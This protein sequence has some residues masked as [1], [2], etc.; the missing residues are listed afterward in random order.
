MATRCSPGRCAPRQAT[1]D[2][3]AAPSSTAG[4][5][6]RH[7]D[8]LLYRRRLLRLRRR[9]PL[10]HVAPRA[11]HAGER[12]HDGVRREQRLIGQAARPPDPAAGSARDASCAERRVV[13]TPCLLARW[14]R[15]GEQRAERSTAR[16]RRER[17][18]RPRER[19]SREEPSSRRRARR[20]CA[21]GVTLR[22]MLSAIFHRES[23]E[24]GSRFEPAAPGTRDVNQRSSCQS[25]RIHRC[26]RRVDVR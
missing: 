19:P 3:I 14:T 16:Q 9:L 1:S 2:R 21:I 17:D 11:E 23:A 24:S 12:P 15:G 20:A 5:M 13:R 4:H 7:T 10:E 22:R 8:D 26:V 18:R 25:P 6:R